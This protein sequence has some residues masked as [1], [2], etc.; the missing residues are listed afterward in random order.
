CAITGRIVRVGERATAVG[1]PAFGA[2]RHV[3]RIILAAMDFDPA[4]R[5]AMNL[6]YDEGLVDR[7]REKGLALGTFDRADE[8]PEAKTMEWGTREAI[9][10]AEAFP[11]VIYDLGG[12]EKVAMIRFLGAS[13]G[14][15]VDRVRKVVG[16]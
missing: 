15:V 14:E 10:R 9:R 12:P 16:P 4:R 7:A 13:P 1:P 3:A 5:S 8:P 11:D 2:S 6:R